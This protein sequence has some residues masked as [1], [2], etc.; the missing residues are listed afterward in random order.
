MIP[1]SLRIAGFLSYLEPAELDFT[2]FDLACISGS[3]GAGK[4]SLLDAITWALFGQARR[5]DNSILNNNKNNKAAE[6]TFIFAYEGNT[7]RVQRTKPRDKATMLEFHIQDA[8]GK[9]KPLTESTMRATEARISQTLRLDYDTFI[10]AS[11]FLQGKADLFAQQRPGDR[12]RILSNILGLEIWETYKERAAEQ[13]KQQ[14]T[15]LAG[16]D[17]R[18]AEINAELG[19]EQERRARL[20]QFEDDLEKSRALRQARQGALDALHRLEASLTNQRKLVEALAGQLATSRQR[21]EQNQAKLAARQADRERYQAQLAAADEIRGRLSILAGSPPR[22]GAPGG[23]RRALY[24]AAG[25][26]QRG[27]GGHRETTL[28]VGAGKPVPGS[29]VQARCPGCGADPPLTTD[30]AATQ[31]AIHTLTGQLGQLPALEAEQIGQQES[32]AALRANNSQLSSDMKV[33]DERI[34]RLAAVDEALCPL[35]GQPLSPADRQVLLDE[36]S[37]QGKQMGDTYRAN[38][39]LVQ[40]AEQRIQELA[41]RYHICAGWSKANCAS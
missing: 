30:L 21:L 34:K 1:L 15:E 37:A 25:P 35:C 23:Y 5:K 26:A 9:W 18:L 4:S 10:N 17:A 6:V 36:L 39:E 28:L 7:Y 11:F 14:E 41:P 3:N 8:G 16:L 31:A 27:A 13:R 29:P 33:L 40:Q 12:K 19:Q 38:K 24:A 22:V 20:K 32:T 2:R